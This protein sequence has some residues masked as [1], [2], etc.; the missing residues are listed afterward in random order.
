MVEKGLIG[1]DEDVRPF[2]PGLNNL[3]V[4]VGWEG[5]D[6]LDDYIFDPSVKPEGNPIFEDVKSKITLR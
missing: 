4:L 2:L 5:K 6:D 1:L 3:Q